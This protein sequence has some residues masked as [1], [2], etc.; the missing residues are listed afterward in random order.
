MISAALKSGEVGSAQIKLIAQE[1]A[2][3]N[4]DVYGDQDLECVIG[5]AILNCAIGVMAKDPSVER[6]RTSTEQSC[7]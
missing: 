6:M 7:V 5:G 2:E 3:S 4:N 1:L